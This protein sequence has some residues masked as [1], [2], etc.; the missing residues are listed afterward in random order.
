LIWIRNISD[1]IGLSTKGRPGSIGQ[2]NPS[3]FARSIL[4]NASFRLR[5]RPCPE[6]P[7]EAAAEL[8]EGQSVSLSRQ[9]REELFCSKVAELIKDKA[10][11]KAAALDQLINHHGHDSI[12]SPLRPFH[13]I[14]EDLLVSAKTSTALIPGLCL[15]TP[16][17]SFAYLS[18]ASGSAAGC[19]AALLPFTFGASSCRRP[20]MTHASAHQIV[21]APGLWLENKM[22]PSAA[23]VDV[24]NLLVPYM[25]SGH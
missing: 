22:K 16:Y 2:S 12:E 1:Y 5:D 3:D 4:K 19:P 11:I 24:L 23:A 20:M 14:V 10:P 9:D 15:V 18:K 13:S 25:T 8:H 21:E 6:N 17:D 7:H